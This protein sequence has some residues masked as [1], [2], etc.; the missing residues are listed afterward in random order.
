MTT[1]DSP[2]HP[3][4][5]LKR[6]GTLAVHTLLSLARQRVGFDAERC[7]LVI[8]HL[9]TSALLR[10]AVHQALEPLRL[11]ELQL[12][13]LLVLFS[14]EPAPAGAADLALHAGVSRAAIAEALDHLSARKLVARARGPHDRRTVLVRLTASG[15][16]LVE[17]AA[18]R[19][20]RLLHELTRFVDTRARDALLSG[21][22][23][24]QEGA[25][26]LET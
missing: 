15:R 25:V 17:P 6:S 16:A 24:L 9:D 13:V 26:T 12:G 21:Y 8:E 20:V 11:S 23:L 1:S 10:S 2:R 7:R 14:L 5:P 19:L 22:A 3:S 18:L 4:R